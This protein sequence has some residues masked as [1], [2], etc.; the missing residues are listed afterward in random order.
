VTVS[1]ALDRAFRDAYPDVP[2]G[3]SLIASSNVV[4]V[5]ALAVPNGFG[6]AGLPTSLSFVARAFDEAKLVEIGRAYQA[7]SDWH[8]RR[9]AVVTPAGL[10]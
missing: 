7:R 1:S 2:G 3:G 9:P 4:G 5:P 8:Q 6:P 10:P